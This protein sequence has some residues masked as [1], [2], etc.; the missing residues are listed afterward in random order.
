MQINIDSAANR[1]Q[2][3]LFPGNELEPTLEGKKSPIVVATF[4]YSSRRELS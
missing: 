1:M 3:Y 2:R 4:G